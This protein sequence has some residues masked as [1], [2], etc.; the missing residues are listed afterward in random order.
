MFKKSIAITPLTTDTANDYF[1]NIRGSKF[2]QDNSFLATLRALV[3]PRIKDGE[4]ITLGF[5]SSNYDAQTIGSVP[6]DRVVN[7]ICPSV[8]NESDGNLIIHSFTSSQ[9][10]NLANMRLIESKFTSCNSGYFRLEKVKDFYRKSFAVDCYINA[11]RRNVIVF[12]DNLDTKKLHYLQVSVLAF[13]PWYFNPSDGVS[14]LEMELLY[15]LRETSSEKYENCIMR[16]AEQY[17]FRTARVRK[18][19]RG[20]ETRYEQIECE[21]ARN[22]IQRCDMEIDRLNNSIGAML[23]KRNDICIKLL[24]LERKIA[25]GGEDSEIMDYFLC[26]N[27]LYLESVTNNDMYFCVKDYL[28]YFD[29]EMAERSINNFRSYVYP[30]GTDGYRG[31]AAEDMK[32][33]MTEIFLADTPQLRIR[34][35]A[36][37]RFDLNGSVSA[38][39][40][41][42]FPMEFAEYMPNTHIDRYSCIGNYQRAINDLLKNRNYI[43]A[44]EQC[45]ASCKSLNFG[46]SPVM[47]EFMKTLYGTNNYNNRCIELPDGRVVKPVDAIRWLRQQE[48]NG[49]QEM[50]ETQNE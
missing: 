27:K 46:D 18:M 10:N 16:I 42:E 15:S 3:A 12:V 31:I 49:E 11:E 1:Q 20:F 25:E 9:E 22:E 28:E 30:G 5:T 23:G 38:M 13:L 24:G 2:G 7:A 39:S 44:L 32:K 4:S 8:L 50:E 26:N 36:A 21:K 14:E 29:P 33:L 40:N 6:G 35:C 43:G 41:H 34:F 47:S 48:N 17:D 45:I 37:Y 19:L